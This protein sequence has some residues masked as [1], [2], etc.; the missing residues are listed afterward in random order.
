MS[1]SCVREVLMRRE[2]E[3]RNVPK[4]GIE[5]SQRIQKTKKEE[6]RNP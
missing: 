6:R 1:L 4:L 2:R 5:I 3:Q